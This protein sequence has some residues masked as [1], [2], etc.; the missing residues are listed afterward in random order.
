MEP[1][2]LAR[3]APARAARARRRPGARPRPQP[4]STATSRRCGS[5]DSDPAGFCWLEPNDA[6]AQRARVR[7]RLARTASACSCSSANLSPV[8]REGY[9]LGLPRGGRWR[10]AAQHRLRAST[11]AATSATSAASSPSRSRGTASPC[12]R[13]LTLPPLA[14]LW[15]VP[16]S[17]VTS[18]RAPAAS[19]RGQSTPYPWERPL[20]ARVRATAASSSASGRRARSR[21]SLRAA[22]RDVALD[23]AGY[24][25][26]EAVAP[27]GAGDDYWFV[28]RRPAA[29][30]DP[31]SRW[32]PD[33]PA[34][35]LRGSLDASPAADAASPRRPLRE[36][37]DL[38]AARRH[39]HAGG[40]VRRRDPAPAASSRELGV[41]AIE[42]MPVAEFPGAPRLGL[43]RRLHLGARSRPTAGPTGSQRLVDAA[44]ARRPRGDPRRRLQP[45][46]R[47]A[48][49]HALEAFGPYFTEQ[50]R[51]A[52]GQGD[53]LR[54]RR[55]R[56]GA[57]VGARRAPSGWVRDFGVDGLRL[58]AIHAIFDSSAEHIV[59]ERR[60]A[61]ARRST[62]GALVIAE[63]GL[64]D[65]RV[66]RDRA[67][68]GWGCDAAWADDF[69]HA[70]R[71]LVDRRARRLLR[72]LRPV[73]QLA[74]AFHR[75]YV[76]D[77]GYSSFRRRRFGA[78]ADDVPPERFVVFCQNHDQ[79]GNRAFGDRLPRAGAAAGRVLHAAL[80][81]R[82]DAVHGRGV[83]RA[84]AVPVLLRPHRREHRR[85]DAR[86]PPRSEFA[87]FARSRRARSPTR[88][89]AATFERSKLT[90]RRDPALSRLYARA[91]GRAP[92]PPAG[93]RRRDRV[94]RGRALA[95]RRAA[96]RSSSCATSPPSRAACRA[97]A[98]SV[99]ARDARRAADA[100]RRIRR[101]RRRCRER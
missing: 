52:V 28:R 5:V 23:D 48:A 76:Y 38:R 11:A 32:Q 59:A 81:V 95:A 67:A 70:L 62:R 82:A 22:S 54:R 98:T 12:R 99:D 63:S 66:M 1:R 73:A 64:N 18:D 90:R 84:R 97:R 61:R 19:A 91:A 75:P 47:V 37:V 34:R 69:H 100:A 27:A 77:G 39:V 30:P 26:Y 96:A 31:C 92:A 29:L 14:A 49:S 65:P 33:G 7:A 24:G 25:V 4:R 50:V 72:G 35:A 60:A 101:A 51:D 15:L 45:R 2:A 44:H 57:R 53:Q 3:L 89:T 85:G 13:E 43:R 94:R 87:A 56:P 8:P 88:R 16:G 17:P 58:D 86:G 79:V 10:E 20:G 55:L 78:P 40:H 83:R 68:G 42:L 9:R 21:C 41:T 80:A 6:D 93:R 71:T 46:R 74:K 36:L